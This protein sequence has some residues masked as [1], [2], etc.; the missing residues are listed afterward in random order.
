MV[1]QA[2]DESLQ[3]MLPYGHGTEESREHV[4]DSARNYVQQS[5]KYLVDNSTLQFHVL[6]MHA[7][8]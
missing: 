6:D 7:Q 3:E 2:N 1:R 4:K 5:N 8:L